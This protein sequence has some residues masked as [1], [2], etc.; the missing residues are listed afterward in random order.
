MIW[1]TYQ[2]DAQGVT[3]EAWLSVV[4]GYE[5]FEAKKSELLDRL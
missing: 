3:H 5:E 2:L 1:T 4:A